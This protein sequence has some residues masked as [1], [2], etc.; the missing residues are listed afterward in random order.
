MRLGIYVQQTAQ[1]TKIPGFDKANSNTSATVNT[2]QTTWESL[3]DT[4]HFIAGR[5]DKLE[6]S[7]E[8]KHG[9]MPILFRQI[10]NNLISFVIYLIIY[11]AE[12]KAING[13]IV[14]LSMIFKEVP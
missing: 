3:K 13:G 11:L 5:L 8:Q 7:T 1:E 12:E 10:L 9:R 14:E 4:M 2:I 6:K